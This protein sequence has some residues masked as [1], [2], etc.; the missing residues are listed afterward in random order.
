MHNLPQRYQLLSKSSRLRV[1]PHDTPALA[2]GYPNAVMRTDFNA[3]LSRA[4]LFDGSSKM[5]ATP[6]LEPTQKQQSEKAFSDQKV[7]EANP[8]TNLSLREVGIKLAEVAPN[9]TSFET[10][11][12]DLLLKELKAGKLTAG[13]YFVSDRAIWAE[14]SQKV[15]FQVSTNRFRSLVLKT[16]RR[17]SGTFKVYV[18][19]LVDDIVDALFS[20]AATTQSSITKAMASALEK[21]DEG[22]EP[23]ITAAN[24]E[25]Y[26]A[27]RGISDTSAKKK[28]T[29]R[30]GH[31]ENLHWR[32]VAE[33]FIG[34]CIS[35]EVGV[36]TIQA[37]ILKAL[38]SIANKRSLNMSG[39]PQESARKAMLSAAFSIAKQ[40]KETETIN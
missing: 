36:D 13:F 39:W 16:N 8:R 23:F 21:G 3:L 18:H 24:W 30:K 17:A 7:L 6:D 12:Y 2:L 38:P 40:L 19:E 26:L 35:K 34:Y 9:E 33:C 29:P 27:E 32:E 14:I 1:P 37:E 4:K 25:A 22:Y 15:W 5:A 28:T 20:S 10:L 31:P 11:A